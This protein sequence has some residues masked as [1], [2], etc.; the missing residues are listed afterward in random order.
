[1]NTEYLI[2]LIPIATLHAMIPSHWLCFA[3]VGRANNWSAQ[4]TMRVALIAGSLHVLITVGVTAAAVY[5]GKELVQ[6]LDEPSHVIS[7]AVIIA[8]G[9]IYLVLHLVHVGHEHKEDETV[10]SRVAVGA[11]LISISLSPCTPVIPLIIAASEAEFWISLV[12]AL[13]VMASSLGVMLF[14]VWL[15]FHGVSAP[16]F[17]FLDRYEKLIIGLILCVLGVVALLVH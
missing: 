13:V 4:R 8:L 5:V 10:S 7:A 9:I 12:T 1:M 15:G 17:N 2:T 11:L 6:K 3:L 14:L 16:K